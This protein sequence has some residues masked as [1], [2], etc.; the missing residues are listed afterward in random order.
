MTTGAAGYGY[1]PLND[2]VNNWGADYIF[3]QPRDILDF[4]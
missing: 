1:I 4:I 2:N 3:N